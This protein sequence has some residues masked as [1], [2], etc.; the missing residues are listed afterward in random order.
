MF[1]IV[2]RL[3]FRPRSA[4]RT[5]R[6]RTEVFQHG[7]TQDR[8]PRIDRNL[9]FRRYLDLQRSTRSFE[10][11][12]AF[13]TRTLAL[14]EGTDTHEAKVTLA[15][16]TYFQ[17]FD[18]RPA[19]GRF[20]GPAEDSVPAGTPVVVLGHDYWQSRY[21]GRGDIIGQQLRI[22]HH[23]HHHRRGP[24]RLRRRQ[25]PGVPAAF[26]PITAYAHAFRGP[27]YPASHTW[28]WMEML[29]RR[30]SEGLEAAADQDLTNAFLASWREKPS[31]PIPPGASSRISA[32]GASWP[33]CTWPAA[34]RRARRQSGHLGPRRRRDRAADC[35]RQRRQPFPVPCAL[36]AAGSLPC[37]WR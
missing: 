11:F 28:S 33:R 34:P 4:S 26:I 8:Q 27:G 16:A 10:S 5:P 23:L 12:A 31:S 35:L 24:Q 22:D 15:S 17:F 29:A 9:N 25:R 19:L 32:S 7:R 21:G 13:Q 37:G 14:G 18:V 3:L 36:P 1:G 6:P 20:Y 30:K 2:D